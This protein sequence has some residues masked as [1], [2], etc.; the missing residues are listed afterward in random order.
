M[1]PH[2]I[3]NAVLSKDGNGVVLVSLSLLLMVFLNLFIPRC[4]S[5]IELALALANLR[6]AIALLV[7]VVVS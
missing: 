7:P 2:F 1:T 3:G 5:C 6:T 4:P